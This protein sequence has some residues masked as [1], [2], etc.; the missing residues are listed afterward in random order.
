M[1]PMEADI[2]PLDLDVYVESLDKA[3]D[4]LRK[5]AKEIDDEFNT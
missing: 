1:I 3:F 4:D 2:D 5:M